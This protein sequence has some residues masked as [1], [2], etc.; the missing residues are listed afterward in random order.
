MQEENR[1]TV[2]PAEASMDWKPNTHTI[3]GTANQTQDSL[4]QS[5]ETTATEESII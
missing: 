3:V 1:R 5:E 2:K 4:V